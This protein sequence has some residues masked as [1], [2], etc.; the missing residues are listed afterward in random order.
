MNL[1]L[2]V[3]NPICVWIGNFTL[4][5]WD[6]LWCVWSL[7]ISHQLAI[8]VQSVTPTLVGWLSNSQFI[9]PSHG[10]MTGPRNV[11]LVWVLSYGC[12]CWLM[13]SWG[14]SHTWLGATEEGSLLR[15][16]LRVYSTLTPGS[17]HGVSSSQ[18]RGLG[19][20][21]WKASSLQLLFVKKQQ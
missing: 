9:K 20:S 7:L 8:T 15:S 14:L 6:V 3:S 5:C 11:A 4:W 21:F 2:Q 10:L 19:C 17:P 16:Q 18:H 13:A 1:A 12:T